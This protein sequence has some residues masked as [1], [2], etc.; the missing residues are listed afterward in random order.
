MQLVFNI[1]L[2]QLQNYLKVLW[3]QESLNGRRTSFTKRISNI[4]KDD[5][6]P[7]IT[8]LF[9]YLLAIFLFI[10]FTSYLFTWK[11]DSDFLQPFKWDNLFEAEKVAQ[12]WF[13]KLGALASHLII[14][15][16][17]GLSSFALIL[18]LIR[19]GY[20]LINGEKIS[21]DLANVQKRIFCNGFRI[22]F[23]RTNRFH[24]FF[25]FQ[26]HMARVLLRLVMSIWVQW[27]LVTL[28]GFV[29]LAIAVW[30]RNANRNVVFLKSIFLNSIG[31]S[32]R[33]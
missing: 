11:A 21:L 17:F 30:F 31:A 33:F 28:F 26:W 14:F 15:L 19:I 13:G 23:I 4:L 10:S 16:T 25:S 7:K 2:R 3:Q 18:L 12:N 29:L 24:S 8:G 27:N 1:Y 9:C 32:S 22:N 20:R 5:R 6:L